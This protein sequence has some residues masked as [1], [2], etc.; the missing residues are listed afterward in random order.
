MLK[1]VNSEFLGTPLGSDG[2]YGNVN[3]VEVGEDVADG[4]QLGGAS[5]EQVMQEDIILELAMMPTTKKFKSLQFLFLK[6]VIQFH[7]VGV[8][9]SHPS[10]MDD[11]RGVCVHRFMHGMVTPA[12]HTR[13]RDSTTAT[14]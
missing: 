4:A 9:V 12:S 1:E 6:R 10:T 2:K 8:C 11:H 3:G 14:R 5:A 13:T 7:T